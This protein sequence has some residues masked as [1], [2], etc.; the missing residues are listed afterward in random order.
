M[1]A[2][3]TLPSLPWHISIHHSRTERWGYW[4]VVR[5]GEGGV[6]FCGR[7][8][9]TW[10]TRRWCLYFT[11]LCRHAYACLFTSIDI[12]IQS[13]K[14]LP[15]VP[16]ILISCFFIYYVT[17]LKMYIISSFEWRVGWAVAYSFPVQGTCGEI[18][19]L[20]LCIQ[21]YSQFSSSVLFLP[22]VQNT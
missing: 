22:P 8:L 20:W 2:L 14:L 12:T 7:W 9:V 1:H 18:W 4:K 15:C 11:F 16:L 10:A 19:T 3:R 5:F 6:F 21:C 17:L 13:A